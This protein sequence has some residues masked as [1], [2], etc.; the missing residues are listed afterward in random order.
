MN[1]SRAVFSKI[2]WPAHACSLHTKPGF[3]VGWNVRSFTACVAAVISNVKLSDLETTL[4]ALSTDNSSSFIY[5]ETVCGEPPIVLGVMTT[6]HSDNESETDNT[7][8]EEKKKSASFWMT[9]HLQ[10]NNLPSL[11]SIHC[12]G[13]RY[14]DVS[15]EIIFY[16]QPNPTRLQYLS[17]EPLVLDIQQNSGQIIEKHSI[18]LKSRK[19]LINSQRQMNTMYL[20]L[21]QINSSF[22][23]EKAILTRCRLFTIR[24]N[25]RSTSVSE[26]VKKSAVGIGKFIKN[27]FLYPIHYAIPMIRPIIAQPMIYLLML[28]R[29]FA[30]LILWI[31]NLRFPTWM[32]NGTALKDLSATLQQIDLRL[33]QACFWPWQYMLLRRRDWT[34]TATTRAQYISFYNSMWLVA[35]DIIIGVT[36]GS[37]LFNNSEHVANIILKEYLDHYTIAKLVSMIDWLMGWPAGLKLNSDLNK[38]MGELF[39]WL[40]DLWRG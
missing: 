4:S 37:F 16:K 23:T 6:A 11:R 12:C 28:V 17:L 9:M 39:L 25:R 5:M 40:I 33:Q 24:R 34:N 27:S 30:E 36:F 8:L 38:F 31:L 18:A 26:T 19:K 20:I 29:I 13:Y 35:N 2:F 15:S 32:F 14:R 3:L 21:N 1:A 22:E 7:L 10:N